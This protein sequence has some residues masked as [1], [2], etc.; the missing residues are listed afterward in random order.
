MLGLCCL[1]FSLVAVSRGYF[2]VAV[3]GVLTAVASLCHSGSRV[4]G[5]HCA[6]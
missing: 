3:H 6:Q 4:S 5:F 2:L 1:G